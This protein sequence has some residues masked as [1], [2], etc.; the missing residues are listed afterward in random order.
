MSEDGPAHWR[1]RIECLIVA[2]GLLS[3]REQV[4]IRLL[5]GESY[6]NYVTECRIHGVAPT[7][8]LRG[9]ASL[10]IE[11]FIQHLLSHPLQLLWE[12]LRSALSILDSETLAQGIVVLQYFEPQDGRKK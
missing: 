10:L 1:F 6:G 2:P 4:G 3:K 5:A 9:M 11:S 8:R 12:T 7:H